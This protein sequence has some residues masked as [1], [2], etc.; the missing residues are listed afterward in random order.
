M[1]THAE[2]TQ[3]NKSESIANAISQKPGNN[4]SIFQFVDNRPKT[5]VQR[6]LQEIANNSPRTSQLIDSQ[7]ITYNNPQSRQ[8]TSMQDSNNSVAQLKLIV[9]DYDVEYDSSVTD[10]DINDLADF[11]FEDD[12][13]YGVR[14]FTK[15]SIATVLK[16]L[17]SS[18][19]N[20][21]SPTELK[22]R[23]LATKEA[24]EEK[25]NVD[26]DEISG[27]EEVQSGQK[28]GKRTFPGD[29]YHITVKPK[30]ITA[31]GKNVLSLLV[32]HDTKHHNF[33]FWIGKNGE[34]YAGI[35]NSGGH[36]KDTGYILT[37]DNNNIIKS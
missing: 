13:E 12:W 31:I 26:E 3:E 22:N 1:N 4:N 30:I 16:E 21:L 5:I 8:V 10:E 34:I 9:E 19:E 11:L 28:V 36:E 35:N 37:E 17:A 15:E 18:G 14:G 23:I 29:T 6:K 27:V 7:D 32:Y 24:S 25:S 2:K 20:T 33:D